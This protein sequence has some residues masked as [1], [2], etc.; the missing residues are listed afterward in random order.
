MARAARWGEVRNR[1]NTEIP[2]WPVWWEQGVS[3]VQQKN[4]GTEGK[5]SGAWAGRRAAGRLTGTL[6]G[7]KSIPSL[8]LSAEGQ[9]HR[10][11]GEATD[12]EN[13]GAMYIWCG[14]WQPTLSLT[15]PIPAPG[16]AACRLRARRSRAGW[17]S[18]LGCARAGAPGFGR[19]GKLV[20][21][22]CHSRPGGPYMMGMRSGG[23]G[24]SPCRAD[25]HAFRASAACTSRSACFT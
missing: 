6:L 3:S 15:P 1:R 21:E 4:P 7:V 24:A 2:S 22:C 18:L 13:L 17:P 10:L 20:D 16:P 8:P 23:C 14:G 9:A 12:K 5:P 11:I 25:I 19:H